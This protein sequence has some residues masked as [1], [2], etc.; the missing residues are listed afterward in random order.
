LKRIFKLQSASTKY[1]AKQKPK[2]TTVIMQTSS[3]DGESC[4]KSRNSVLCPL[5]FY[6]L[7]KSAS[8]S[9][10]EKSSAAMSQ[11]IILEAGSTVSATEPIVTTEEMTFV[12]S[13]KTTGAILQETSTQT[14]GE[15]TEMSTTT[16]TPAA[17]TSTSTVTSTSTSTSTSTTTTT[18]PVE[19]LKFV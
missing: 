16:L 4:D 17:T 7:D 19:T 11:P 1:K 12:A 18:T 6:T 10:L 8:P 15:T 5:F 13:D 3:T 9:T 2:T 14:I